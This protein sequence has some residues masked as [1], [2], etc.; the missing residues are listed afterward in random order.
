M[1]YQEIINR[2][3]EY[4]KKLTEDSPVHISELKNIPKMGIYVFYENGRPIY[5]G[6]SR[7]LTQR[8]RQHR[9]HSSRHNSA[10]FAFMIA[11]QDAE[12][13]GVDIKRTREELQNDSVFFPIF[14][15]AKKRVSEMHVQVIQMDDPIEQTL[16]EVYAALELKTEH[17]S[18]ET[19]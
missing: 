12:K 19:H 11:K 18:W 9:Q 7:N 13:S 3:P 15:K 5:V 16:F 2:F 6:R 8:F 1:K 14:I 4:M 10:T 17:N